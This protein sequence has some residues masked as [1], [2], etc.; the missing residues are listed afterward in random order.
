MRNSDITDM[1][2][3]IDNSNDSLESLSLLKSL[4][5]KFNNQEL[6]ECAKDYAEEKGLCFECICELVTE[7]WKESRP[8][9]DGCIYEDVSNRV[10][11]ECGE[12]Y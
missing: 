7:S 1:I 6:E 4:V 11:P 5:T 8:F 2:E 10:C 9:G 3:A 12:E